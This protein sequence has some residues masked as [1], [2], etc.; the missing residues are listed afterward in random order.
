MNATPSSDEL[1]ALF[2]LESIAR[3]AI[4]MSGI[5]LSVEQCLQEE[6]RRDVF[7]ILVDDTRKHALM[8][9]VPPDFLRMGYVIQLSERIKFRAAQR[10]EP[11]RCERP[12]H[13]PLVV[14]GM[15]R[16]GTTVLYNLL[17][18]QKGSRAPRLWELWAPAQ[19]AEKVPE[20]GL[21]P[22]IMMAQFRTQGIDNL[23]PEF[24]TI[25]AMEALAP[26]ECTFL[27]MEDFCTDSWIVSGE[28]PAY[29]EWFNRQDIGMFYRHHR[30]VLSY[31]DSFD[32]PSSHWV[33][34]S[35]Y[36]IWH[37]RELFDTY[38]D[39]NVV[40]TH[41]RPTEVIAS[42]IS[43]LTCPQR[44]FI[45]NYDPLPTARHILQQVGALTKA[46]LV[47]RKEI[48]KSGRKGQILD[49]S[50][51]DV[52]ANPAA[53]VKSIYQHFE[54]PMSSSLEEDVYAHL[55]A[56]PKDKAGA[57]KYSLEQYG[58]TPQDVETELAEYIDAFG[59]FWR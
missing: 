9:P 55:A 28:K 19:P 52:M 34:K 49:V 7:Q 22:R 27:F 45:P 15:M 3:D 58:L 41:R 20:G 37:L 50:Y 42:M 32:S 53:V 29:T 25:H 23:L 44:A 47:T 24:K 46:S 31:L 36:H 4:G 13:K 17:A 16:T 38:P 56:H 14:T 21:D 2:D 26:E 51:R 18:V 59:H 30:T 33:L 12:I 11:A 39:V 54:Y 48:E 5:E 57:H 6:P 35:P 10:A 40:M 43:L 1:A 8:G